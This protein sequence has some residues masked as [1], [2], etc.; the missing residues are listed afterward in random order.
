[1]KFISLPSLLLALAIGLAAPAQGALTGVVRSPAGAPIAGAVLEIKGTGASAVSDGQGRFSLPAPGGGPAALVVRSAGWQLAEL[2]LA[3]RTEGPLAVELQPLEVLAQY[4][5]TARRRAEPAQEVPIPI[6]VI[7]GALAEA[8]QSFSPNRLKELV[9]SVQL[10]SSNPRNTAVNIRGQGTTFGLTNDGIDPGVGF[11]VD[12]VYHARP[13]AAALDFIDVERIEVLRGPQGTLFGKNTTAGAFNITTRKPSFTPGGELETSVG[14]LGFRQ[15]R[16]SLTGPL[17]RRLAARASFAGTRREG[18][19][20]NTL[21]RKRVNELDNLGWRG[22]LLYSHEGGL[23]VLLA[24]DLSRQHPE[25]YAQVLAGVAPTLRPAYRQFGAIVADLGYTVPHPEPFARKI[26]QDTPWRSGNDYGGVS[27]TADLELERGTLTA[28][29]AWRFWDWEPSND[30]DFTGLQA[31]ALSQATS[32]HEQ[33]SQ[34]VRWAGRLAARLTGVFGVFALKQRLEPDPQQIEESGRDQWR[35]AQSSPSALWQTPG[36][37]EGYGIRSYPYLDTLSGAVFGQAD[38]APG[39]RWRLLAGLRINYDD[40]QVDYAR[41]TYGGLQTSDPALLALKRSVYSD[42]AFRA[43]VDDTV[44]SGQLTATWAA[45]Q[46]VKTYATYATSHKPVG[47][48]LGGLPTEGAR[49]MT[50]LAVIKPEAVSHFEAGLKATPTEHS[51]VNLTLFHTDIDDY[52]TN[53]QAADLALNRGYLANAERV[54][55]RGAELE[56]HGRRGALALRG[57]LAYTEGVY[58]RFTNAP[59]PLEETGGPTFKDISGGRLPGISRWAGTVGGEFARPVRLL[60]RSREGFVGV[61]VY[62]REGFSSSPSPSRYLNIPGY[63]LTHARLGLRAA[64]GLTVYVWVRNAFARD[65]FE[66][67]LPAGGNAGQYAAVLG[68]P[69]TLGVTLRYRF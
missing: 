12:G 51:A 40:K 64:R 17:G 28:T 54:R 4:Q 27:L 31:L 48:N 68:D 20:E 6:A 43:Q 62:F 32:T 25:G 39:G 65:Y 53:V 61:D 22:Q 34:E 63:S 21:T 10:Y 33:W 23:D 5:V 55:L 35:F 14:D 3:G 16:A 42:Q 11:Y 50:E 58:V 1:M 45:S 37:L 41:V 47:L 49:V 60:G 30:R 24:A 8:T 19:L 52:Q 66:Q 9:P 69:R 67:L 18:T 59:P 36:L 56:A 15:A 29:T 2:A 38:W 26:H 13:A 7:S 44:V 57:A 46:R